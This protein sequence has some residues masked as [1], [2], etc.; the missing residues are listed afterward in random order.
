MEVETLNECE[1]RDREGAVGLVFSL[2]FFCVD[3]DVRACLCSCRKLASE[4]QLL[5]ARMY[6]GGRGERWFSL[7]C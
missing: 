5:V 7:L 1:I 3:F 6:N 4:Y 2:V